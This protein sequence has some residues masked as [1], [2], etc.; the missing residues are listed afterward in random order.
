LGPNSWFLTND[1][2]LQKVEKEYHPK[3]IPSTIFGPYWIQM[4][5]PFLSP[6]ISSQDSSVVFATV[7]GMS[8]TSSHIINEEIWLKIQGP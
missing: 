3:S 8:L 4:I 7:F 5:A 2:T 6:D 1:S